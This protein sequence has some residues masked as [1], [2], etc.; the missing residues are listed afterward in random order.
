[1][2]IH[3]SSAP[4]ESNAS[5]PDRCPSWKIQASAPKLAVRLRMFIATALIGTITEPVMR[6]SSTRVVVTTR[7]AAYGRRSLS[8]AFTSMSSAA[9]P[10]TSLSKVGWVSRS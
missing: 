1:M 3:R 4:T 5:G 7:R 10:P 2:G 9:I 6:N 8:R